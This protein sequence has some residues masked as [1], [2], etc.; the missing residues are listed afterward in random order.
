MPF[1]LVIMAFVH[2]PQERCCHLQVLL[3]GEYK[4]EEHHTTLY[5]G[6]VVEIG[7]RYEY[8]H[9]YIDLDYSAQPNTQ[10][11]EEPESFFIAVVTWLNKL[12]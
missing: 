11:C 10:L 3:Q 1:E 8:Y 9:E 12:E 5:H 2:Q 4:D 7:A 6:N